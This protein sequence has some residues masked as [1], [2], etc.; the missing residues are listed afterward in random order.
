M[1]IYTYIYISGGSSRLSFSNAVLRVTY[2][3]ANN[4]LYSYSSRY[5][6]RG[7]EK[8]KQTAYHTYI[9]MMI[10]KYT[11]NYSNLFVK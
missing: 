10:E 4:I 8:T 1:I 9:Y 7:E 2:K 6:S 11:G 5:Q 3:I